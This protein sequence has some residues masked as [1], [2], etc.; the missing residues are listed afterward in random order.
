[1]K[2]QLENRIVSSFLLYVDHEIQRLGQA[3]KNFSGLLYPASGKVN[4]L[5]VY[6]APFKPLCNDTSID[7]A[8]VLSGV[9]LNGN[10]V[11]YGQS[12]LKYINH[13][14]GALYFTGQLPANTRVSG[15]YAI[16]EFG[17]ELAD[18]TEWDLLF[19][20]K[21]VSNNYYNQ[22]VSGLALESKTAPIIYVIPKAQE[23]KPFA[24]QHID[25]NTL[26]LR[27]L[28]IADTL[29]QN[30][31][32]SSILKNLN[33]RFIPLVTGIPFDSLGNNTGLAYNYHQA[34][35]NSG[36]NPWISAVR[37]IDVPQKGEF[38]NIQRKMSIVDFDIST[39]TVN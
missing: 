23:N 21:Y 20:T 22:T 35:V 2:P 33:T 34:A 12:G 3:Y 32:V 11:T 7:G 31:A 37:K 1:M 28:V 25:N 30:L 24:F 14:Q 39:I 15:N 9:Y 18:R 16:K 26:S 6:T 36:I 10:F 19:E 8:N 17:V 38:A 5:Y 4:G 29:S 13:Y 27:C